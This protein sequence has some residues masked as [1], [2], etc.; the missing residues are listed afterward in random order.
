MPL[1]PKDKLRW[2]IYR[3]EIRIRQARDAAQDE[4][5]GMKRLREA[6]QNNVGGVK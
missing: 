6:L 4:R 5:D 1:Q 3:L 2:Q